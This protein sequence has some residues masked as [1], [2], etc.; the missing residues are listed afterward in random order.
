MLVLAQ[1]KF[2][3]KDT[4]LYVIGGITSMDITIMFEFCNQL[5]QAEKNTADIFT[6]I[7]SIPK[8]LSLLK[9]F[10]SGIRKCIMLYSRECRLKITAGVSLENIFFLTFMVPYVTKNIR[11]ISSIQE[12]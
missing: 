3:Q 9:L 1:K 6:K 11:T 8:S 7:I 10:F 2:Y 12:N 4:N 5:V